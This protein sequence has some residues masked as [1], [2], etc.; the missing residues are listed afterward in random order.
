MILS[1]VPNFL[2]GRLDV[3]ALLLPGVNAWLQGRHAKLL[4]KPPE[5]Q[6]KVALAEP[7]PAED[8]GT[9]PACSPNPAMACIS[10]ARSRKELL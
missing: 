4:R 3:L 1:I 2:V 8:P 9:M 6:A 5:R 10:P 7:W